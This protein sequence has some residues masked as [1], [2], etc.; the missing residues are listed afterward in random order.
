MTKYVL[1]YHG[2]GGM[3]ETP[4]AQ[5]EV[6]AAWGAWFAQLGDAVV[7]GGNPFGESRTV[8]PDGS[9]TMSGE[10]PALSGYSLLQADSLDAAVD[11]AKGCPVLGSGGRVQVSEAIDM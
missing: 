2:G 8:Q 4:E 6:M 9:V 5:E 3:A 11:A 1:T 10:A 7:D